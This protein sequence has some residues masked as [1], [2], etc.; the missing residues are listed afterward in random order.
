MANR[1]LF[2]PDGSEINRGNDLKVDNRK[3]LGQYLSD[4]TSGR[5][6]PSNDPDFTPTDYQYTPRNNDFPIDGTTNEELSLSRDGNRNYI[7]PEVSSVQ[8]TFAG[9]TEVDRWSRSDDSGN[10]GWKAT[11][12]ADRAGG[13]QNKRR[14]LY[15]MAGGNPGQEPN[16]YSKKLRDGVTSVLAH[17]AFTQ[18]RKFITRPD[19]ET[20]GISSKKTLADMRTAALNALGYSSGIRTSEGTDNSAAIQQL[21]RLNYSPA[22]VKRG[23]D[24][25]RPFLKSTNENVDKSSLAF[26]GSTDGGPGEDFSGLPGQYIGAGDITAQY[27]DD[28][29]GNSGGVYTGVTYG[30]KDSPEIPFGN[31]IEAASSVL[32]AIAA[33]IA[34]FVAINVWSAVLSLIVYKLDRPE[35]RTGINPPGAERDTSIASDLISAALGV[36]RPYNVNTLVAGFEGSISFLGIDGALGGVI[37]DAI[38]NFAFSPDYYILICR[39][40]LNGVYSFVGQTSNAGTGPEGAIAALFNLRTNKLVTFVNR[41]IDIGSISLRGVDNTSDTSSTVSTLDYEEE[42]VRRVSRSRQYGNKLAWRSSSTAMAIL[43]PQIMI[44]GSAQLYKGKPNAA[45]AWADRIVKGVPLVKDNPQLKDG[46]SGYLDEKFASDVEQQLNAEY[47][48]FYFKD[49]R[50]NEIISFHAFLGDLSDSFTANY[51]SSEGFG[52]QD[53]VQM[54]KGTTRAISLSFHVVSTSP[55]DHDVM[56]YKINKLISMLYPQYTD[57][58]RVSN[59]ETSFEVPFSQVYGAS[60][61]I[62]LR[63]GDVISS[64]YS[65][66]G[67]SRLFGLGKKDVPIISGSKQ[68]ITA[69]MTEFNNILDS[70]TLTIADYEKSLNS[71]RP[72][73]EIYNL[74]GET[75]KLTGRL[76]RGGVFRG[77]TGTI[78]P[79][80]RTYTV[81]LTP[82]TTFKMADPGLTS[83]FIKNVK[84][85]LDDNVGNKNVALVNLDNSIKIKRLG[86]GGGGD[87]I[88]IKQVFIPYELIEFTQTVTPAQG[89]LSAG[90]VTTL[91]ASYNEKNDEF[92]QFFNPQENGT[93]YSGNSIVRSFESSMGQGLAGVITSL[94]MDWGDSTWETD[95][96]GSKAPI[97]LK[98]TMNFTPIHDLP[99]GLDSGGIM[100]APAYPVG[101][102]IRGAHGIDIASANGFNQ[103]FSSLTTGE[104]NAVAQSG[105]SVRTP[106]ENPAAPY[107]KRFF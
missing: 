43:T 77:T 64:N 39:M 62:R 89:L 81:R 57:G 32:A 37:G 30:T 14:V 97:W 17:N 65:R 87:D 107:K 70:K 103:G 79:F 82:N 28:G 2:A 50:T 92:V 42:A 25:L 41:M 47:V 56:W 106:N 55:K 44:E 104:Y 72:E 35:Y 61:L 48:P 59:Q 13:E 33:A 4:R 7:L 84:P 73:S 88:E 80:S 8:S 49:L 75:K 76:I 86:P 66:F 94:N 10:V 1:T 96:I 102:V 51:V 5:P 85:G 78:N 11:T 22:S 91:N 63:I 12:Q 90:I 20:N 36:K 29:L 69:G 93:Y 67:L 23:V 95:R 40:V 99:M 16:E 74:L 34:I 54:Y 9:K 45:S 52:R 58:I 24:G 3:K 27:P 68:D 38:I 46:S 83:P 60:P 98:I 53:P 6:S 31:L 15:E 18:D 100:T 19:N 21:I 26:E 71:S 101:D 105:T